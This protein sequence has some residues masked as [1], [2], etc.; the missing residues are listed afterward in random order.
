MYE[1]RAENLRR[2]VARSEAELGELLTRAERDR[3]VRRLEKRVDQLTK[4]QRKADYQRERAE[5]ER[6][7]REVDAAES[8][9]TAER[10][11][12]T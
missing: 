9:E 12:E 1:P 4:G 6:R 11:V 8:A 5:L 7:L 2:C 3:Q 10:A